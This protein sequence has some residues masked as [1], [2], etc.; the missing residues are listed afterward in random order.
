[1]FIWCVRGVYPATLPIFEA[2]KTLLVIRHAKSSWDHA[3]LKD[4]DRPLN[5]RG[6]RDA[7]LMAARTAKAFPDMQRLVSS[8]AVRALSTARYFQAAWK[9][10][11]ADLLVDPDIYE[12]GTDTLLGVIRS[13]PDWIHTVALFGHNPGF[14][15]LVTHLGGT[16]IDMPTCCVAQLELE[17]AD[18]KLADPQLSRL[19]NVDYPKKFP[20]P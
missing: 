15:Q 8:P 13:F 16:S 3:G 10:G 14:S 4:I 1:M 18:W 11:Q 20:I 17:M 12:A 19:V 6:L 9:P 2:M 5:E 7:P